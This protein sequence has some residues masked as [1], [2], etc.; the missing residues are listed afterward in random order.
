[1]NNISVE[2][3]LQIINKT[4]ENLNIKRDQ[5]GENLL[6]LGLDS[7]K[8]IQMVVAIEEAFDCEIPDSKLIMSEMD[9]VEKIMAVLTEL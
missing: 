1:M 8:F 5:I 7:I 2:D 9:T 3:V 4:D 6:D